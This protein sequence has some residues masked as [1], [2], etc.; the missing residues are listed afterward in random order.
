MDVNQDGPDAT[1]GG[2][3]A[4]RLGLVSA[5]SLVIA[6]MIG[7]GLFTTSGFA[8]ADL[9]DRRWVLLAWLLGGVVAV[10]GALS[11]GGIAH[12]IPVSGGEATYLSRALH[13]ALGFMAGWVSV[14]AGFAGPIAAAALALESYLSTALGVAPPA[15]LTGAT[16][17]A[18]AAILHAA[19]PASGVGSLTGLVVLKAALLV[20]FLLW[21]AQRV[22]TGG[23]PALA[24]FDIGAFAV[25]LVWVS[26]SFSGWNGAVYLAGE[27][28]EPERNL[29]R[30]LWLPT[31]GVAVLYLAANALFLYSGD[32]SELAGRADVGAAAA[33]L[34][35]GPTAER[36]VAGIVALALVTSVSVMVL[37]GPRVLAQMARDGM[38]PGVLGRGRAAPTAAIAFQALLAIGIVFLSDLRQLI[39]TLGFT[40]GLSAAVTVGAAVWLRFREGAERVP[41]PGYPVVPALFVGFTLWSSAYLVFRSPSDALTGSVLLMLGLPAYLWSRMRRSRA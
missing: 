9:G 16:V 36:V 3:E 31:V 34:L 29:R 4:R 6:N 25:T 1:S 39:G 28:R 32:P 35:G 19:R 13:P 26:F 10:C 15:G 20:G 11:Y 38:L 17:I 14:F 22:E 2:W 30:A 18:L 33:R 40:L 12:R 24:P 37:S 8:L 23:P 21:G 7:A 27:I 41:M 5:S